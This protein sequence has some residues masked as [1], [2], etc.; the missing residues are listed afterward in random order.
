MKRFRQFSDETNRVGHILFWLFPYEQ[1][2]FRRSRTPG[3]RATRT[4]AYVRAYQN[5]RQVSRAGV[6]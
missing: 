3:H 4:G 6:R 5:V 2:T 1:D